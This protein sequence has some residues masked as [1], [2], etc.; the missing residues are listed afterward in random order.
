MQGLFDHTIFHATAE[1]KKKKKK[2]KTLHTAEREDVKLNLACLCGCAF[3]SS[4]LRNTK[5][6]C[7][8]PHLNKGLVSILE[9]T[10]AKEARARLP[11]AKPCEELLNRRLSEVL[12]AASLSFGEVLGAAHF[13][14]SWGICLSLRSSLLGR[15]RSDGTCQARVLQDQSWE[16]HLRVPLLEGNPARR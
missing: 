3:L 8:N 4:R 12:P 15:V 1:K 2:K 6:D 16:K 11:S 14:L 5:G 10:V 9:P 7:L 13:H